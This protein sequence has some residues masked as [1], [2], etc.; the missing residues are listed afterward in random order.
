MDTIGIDTYPLTKPVT[1]TAT[2]VIPQQDPA[3]PP[4]MSE[5][6]PWPLPVLKPTWSGKRRRNRGLRPSCERPFAAR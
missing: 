6:S 4:S 3:A 5:G 1:G 2:G